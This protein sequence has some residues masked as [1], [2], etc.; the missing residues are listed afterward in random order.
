MFENSCATFYIRSDLPSLIVLIVTT[1]TTMSKI[2]S[3]GLY[4]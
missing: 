3:H 2:S 4:S 1:S